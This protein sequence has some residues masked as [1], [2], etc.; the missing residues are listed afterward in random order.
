MNSMVRLKPD[1]PSLTVRLKPDTTYDTPLIHVDRSV[2]LQ[3]D[4]LSSS[5]SRMLQSSCLAVRLGL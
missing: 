2:R 3:P 4:L 1:T 5:S